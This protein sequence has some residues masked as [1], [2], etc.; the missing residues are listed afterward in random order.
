MFAS[1]RS[2]RVDFWFPVKA[3]MFT[4]NC[5]VITYEYDDGQQ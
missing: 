4:E 2:E 3:M 5:S 1:N